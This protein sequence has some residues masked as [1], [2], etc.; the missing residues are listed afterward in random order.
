MKPFYYLAILLVFFGSACRPNEAEGPRENYQQVILNELSFNLFLTSYSTLENRSETLLNTIKS[1]AANPTQNG[2][3][4]CRANWRATRE[5]WE[6]SEAWLFG[7]VS[8]ESIDPRIDT[9]PVDFIRLDSVLNSNA[10]FSNAY[11]N[12]LEESLKGFHPMEY[13]LFGKN[14]NKSV[15]EFDA[16][17]MAYLVALAE[18]LKQL[19]SELHTAWSPQVGKYVDEL[20][21]TGPLKL[22]PNKL[23]AYEEIT[24][25]LIGICD[26]VANG[27]INDVFI[28]LDSMGEE[29]PFAKNSITDFTNNIK[30]VQMV[31]LGPDPSGTTGLVDFVRTFNLSLDARIKQKINTAISALGQ[32]TDPFGRAIFTQPIQVQNAVDAINDLKTELET[33][34]LPLIQVHVK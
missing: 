21:L 27:K 18:N 23:S 10:T 3:D 6:N 14:G 29:S 32:I 22:Y 26:E 8:T 30:G 12:S 7:P 13:L 25:A 19:C 15:S 17:Q 1:Y 24:N 2:L 28:N 16:R 11:I 20:T 31:Y 5:V 34:L 9:W 33:G 4:L